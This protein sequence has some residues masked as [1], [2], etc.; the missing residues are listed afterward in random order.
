MKHKKTIESNKCFIIYLI[1]TTKIIIKNT[2]E[3]DILDDD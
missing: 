3:L 2:K 1:K